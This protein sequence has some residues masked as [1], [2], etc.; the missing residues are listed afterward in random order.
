MKQYTAPEIAEVMRSKDYANE[1]EYAV[2]IKNG[3]FVTPC[4]DATVL[5]VDMY[6]PELLAATDDDDMNE[7]WG[8]IEST[9]NPR[10]V[11]AVEELTEKVNTYFEEQAE[12]EAA[13]DFARA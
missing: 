12:K 2:Y 5:T 7:I 8:E 4:S 3:A 13:V 10:Y 6:A 1:I 11:N 9:E